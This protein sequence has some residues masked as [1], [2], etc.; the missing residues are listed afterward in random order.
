MHQG[1]IKFFNESQKF[2]FIINEEGGKEIFFHITGVKNRAMD[3]HSKNKKVT[4]DTYE[5]KKGIEA[6][7]IEFID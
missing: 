6:N 7:N 4:Y 2:G 5:G 3:R 1:I